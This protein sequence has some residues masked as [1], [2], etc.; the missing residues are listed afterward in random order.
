MSKTPEQIISSVPSKKLKKT[1]KI[2]LVGDAHTLKTET[3]I[4]YT[5]RSF[6][7]DYTPTVFTPDPIK[8]RINGIEFK[9]SLWDTA[10]QEDYPILRPLAYSE[11]DVV[12]FM[13]LI[14]RRSSLENIK[15]KWLPEIKDNC[16][17]G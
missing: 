1:I 14:N 4:T 12:F 8:I 11:T 13:F 9:S 5:N 10:G 7:T 15:D 16:E 2:V 17:K 6:P 3:L